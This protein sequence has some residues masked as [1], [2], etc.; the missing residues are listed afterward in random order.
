MPGVMMDLN[1]AD[2]QRIFEVFKVECDEHIQALNRG[3]VALEENPDQ[4]DLIEKI[5]REAHSL[6]GAARMLH[7]SAIERIA[8]AMETM[9]GRVKNRDMPL[10]TAMN[11]LI[12]K[13]LDAIETILHTIADGG[14]EDAVDLSDLFEQLEQVSNTDP[15]H[16]SKSSKPK[17][18]QKKT[19]SALKEDLKLFSEETR[20]A[21]R[22]FAAALQNLRKDPGAL[23]SFKSAHENAYALKG[24]ARMVKH[25]LMGDLSASIEDL[26][27]ALLAEKASIS[28]EILG[29]L[30]RAAYCIE[31]FIA[32]VVT[33]NAVEKPAEFDTLRAAIDAAT[34]YFLSSKSENEV[35][36]KQKKV[37]E[38]SSLSLKKENAASA[39]IKGPAKKIKKP[40]LK[41]MTNTV[42]VSSEKLDN[43]MGQAGELLVLKLKARQRLSDTQAIINDYNSLNREIK[44]KMLSFAKAE[45]HENGVGEEKKH[46][47]NSFSSIGRHCSGLSDRLEFL[48][49]CLFDD[50]RQFS[51]IIERLQEDVRKTRLFPFQ[52]VLDI[53]PRM[54]RDLSASVKKKVKLTTSGG[55]I[56]L[57][58]YILEEIKDPLMHI[59]RNC[60]DHGIENS[61]ERAESKKPVTGQIQI[62]VFQKGNSAVIEVKDDGKGIDL[63]RIKAS[64]IKKGIYSET[65]MKRMKDKQ[66]LNFIFHPGFST[67][68]MITDI[69]GRGV[70]MDVVKSNIEKLNGTIDIET[71][72]GKGTAFVMTIPLTLSTTQSLKI[73]ISGRPFFLPVNMVERIIKVFEHDLPVV[74]GYPA[75]HYSG[76]YIPYVRM[77]EILEIP[78]L[79]SEPDS[80]CEKPVA[81]LKIGKTLAAFAMDDFLGEEEILM[82]GLGNYMKRVRHI[83]GVTMMRDGTVAPVLNVTDM[84]NTVLIRGISPSKI[85]VEKAEARSEKCVLVVD[86]SVMT[87]TLAKNILESY[88]FC[89]LTAADGE[90]AL[91]KLREETVDLIVSDIQ[92]PKMDGLAFT[93]LVKEDEETKHIPVV[94][95]TALESEQDKKQGIEVGADAYIMKSAFDQ[96]NLVSTIKSL[97]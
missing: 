55:N 85:Q 44:N 6:K 54:V 58:K 1:Q 34:S 69:S 28:E 76:S 56:E 18:S 96:S 13:G 26:F 22:N 8:H 66:I 79:A 33:K 88:G 63:A 27:H 72:P 25:A 50:F 38:Q 70:G 15:I 89:V 80:D 64:V 75:V 95:V 90:D 36:K 81:I 47:T 93:R 83:S 71:I 3:L 41:T 60:I 21:H 45:R 57:D 14:S 20:A 7:F 43:L 51:T 78:A 65:E 67:R 94:L 59:I 86:D 46:I 32:Q 31:T 35:L 62:D 23:K 97:L 29:H 87:R 74:E 12:L 16:E 48:Q 11:N 82:K 91:L 92:M 42:R 52:T 30:E 2:F 9:L 73:M 68:A 40:S 39:S 5:F 19:A 49:K 17:K 24:S 10:T 61:Q 53:F 4:A 77:S 84:M 37:P